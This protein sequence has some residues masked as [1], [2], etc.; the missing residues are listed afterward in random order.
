LNCAIKDLNGVI[1]Q[2][3]VISNKP[4]EAMLY[5]NLEQLRVINYQIHVNTLSCSKFTVNHSLNWLLAFIERLFCIPAMFHKIN[6][7]TQ[8]CKAIH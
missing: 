7:Q 1:N 8:K 5:S 2:Y 4:Q 3:I 6:T